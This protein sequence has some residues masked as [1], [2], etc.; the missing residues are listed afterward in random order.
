V[1]KGGE[2]LGNTASGEGGRWG[3]TKDSRLTELDITVLLD[4][5]GAAVANGEGG[6]WGGRNARRPRRAARAR[7]ALRAHVR[8]VDEGRRCHD[9][10]DSAGPKAL[11]SKR[12]W[13]NNEG[14]GVD[15]AGGRGMLQG[16]RRAGR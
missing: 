5:R 2:A 11:V 6:R 1:L 4:E 15:R 14:S 3:D 12:V 9:A 7:I 8:G 10:K 13:A 16:T